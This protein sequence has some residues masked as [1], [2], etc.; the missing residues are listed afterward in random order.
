MSTHQ[1]LESVSLAHHWILH[2][3]QGCTLRNAFICNTNQT[4]IQLSTRQGDKTALIFPWQ[5]NHEQN[6]ISRIQGVVEEVLRNV[7]HHV[8]DL[9]QDLLRHG[10]QQKIKTASLRDDGLLPELAKTTAETATKMA[11]MATTAR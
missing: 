6:S 8:H 2:S 1:V 11:R 10:G 5:H 3:V 7:F 9:V 4:E